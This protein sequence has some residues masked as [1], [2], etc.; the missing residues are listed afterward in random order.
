MFEQ[1]ASLSLKQAR[2]ARDPQKKPRNPFRVISA[3]R[4]GTRHTLARNSFSSQVRRNTRP[5]TIAITITLNYAPCNDFQ[6]R[7]RKPEWLFHP[8]V[9]VW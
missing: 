8:S 7:A 9:V 4:E 2:N 5:H 1:A 3:S 6:N